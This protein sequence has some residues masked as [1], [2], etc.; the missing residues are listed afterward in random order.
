MRFA[1]RRPAP[2]LDCFVELLWACRGEPRPR[3]L[4]RV[5]PIGAPQ[6]VVNLTEDE[7]RTYRETASGLVCSTTA[8]SI[9]TGITTRAQIIDTDEQAYTA[10]VAFRPGGTVAFAAV[11]GVE[12]TDIDAPLDDVWSPRAVTRLRERLLEA[13]TLESM[14]DALEVALCETLRP[15]RR[16]PAVAFAIDRF[17]APD[18]MARVSDV[19]D[20][21]ALSP[22]R[23]IERF[24]TE[25]GLTPKRYCRL[26][27]FQAAVARAH[28]MN[29]E[30]WADLAA[31][32]GYFD[33]A[34][35][36]HD[37]RE[38]SGMTPGAYEAGRTPF[39]NHVTFLQSEPA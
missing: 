18:G 14:L 22:K 7:T 4:E 15:G 35:F 8:G 31:A 13:P 6:L 19:T 36:I 5:L 37:F 21:I 10:G 2:P 11:P 24:K 38:F 23:F 30:A 16:H 3:G 28:R 39:Q 17:A 1:H 34:H 26:L 20:V 32:C 25:V 27:R 9:V 33:Q 12:L 29:G